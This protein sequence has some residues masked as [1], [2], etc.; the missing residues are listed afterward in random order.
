M[1]K[2]LGASL[3]CTLLGSRE[4]DAEPRNV[5]EAKNSVVCVSAGTLYAL[6]GRMKSSFKTPPPPTNILFRFWFFSIPDGNIVVVAAPALHALYVPGQSDVSLSA[7]NRCLPK[8]TEVG[9]EEAKK[10]DE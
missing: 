1:S 10:E 4:G 9:P 2:S 5:Q 6:V 7:G 8:S 3:N